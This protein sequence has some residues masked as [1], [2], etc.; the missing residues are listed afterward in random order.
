VERHERDHEPL[1]RARHRLI[2]GHLPLHGG[3][4]WREL[5]RLNEMKQLLAGHIGASPV[6]HCGDGVSSGLKAQEV[7]AS[8]M[9]KS[10]R[11]EMRAW[12]KKIMGKQSPEPVP[13]AWFKGVSTTLTFN[14]GPAMS[15]TRSPARVPRRNRHPLTRRLDPCEVRT[16]NTHAQS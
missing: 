12:R 1:G 15:A 9:W 4:E 16:C 6:R 2:A 8:R 11:G 5:A 13:D 14:T 3:G 10:T 7:V